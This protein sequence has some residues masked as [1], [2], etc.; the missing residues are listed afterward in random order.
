MSR[1]SIRVGIVAPVHNRKEITLQ[2]LR[3]LSR[4]EREG[5]DVHIVIV[6]DGSTDGTSETIR[7]EF[8]S[9]ELIQ[10][11]GSLWFTEGTNVGI[12]GALKHDPKYVLLINDDSLFDPHFLTSLVETAETNPRSVVGPLL[13]LW[14]EPHKVFQ[15]SPVWNT[16]RGGWRHWY[17]QTVWTVPKKPW[18]VD[19]IVG[20][21]VLVPAEAMRELGLMNSQRYPNFGDAEFTPR[22]KRG[23]WQLVINPAARVFCQPNT[24]PPRLRKM[25]LRP[26]YNDLIGDLG[27][28]HNLRRRA[29]SY[30]D[31]APSKLKGL[32]GFAIFMIRV[33]MGSRPD[34]LESTRHDTEEPLSKTFASA[35]IDD[36]RTS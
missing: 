34:S 26:L 28:N 31:G 3:S 30:I 14:D 33:L 8:P 25:G 5:I 24:P 23:G 17:Q 22:L 10:A 13:L 20:N 7:E 2:C 35:V 1:E 29:Y 4:I 12:R 18:N 32:V 15:T 36:E 21:C 11:D 9:V 6:D 16:W 19:I 27:R